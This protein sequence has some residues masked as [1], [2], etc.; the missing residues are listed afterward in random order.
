MKIFIDE[1]GSFNWHNP[2]RSIFCG[3]SIPDRDLSAVLD[4]F[5]RWRRSIIGHSKRELKGAELTDAQLS[6]FVSKVLP[7][8]DKQIW[9]TIVG[10]DT[11]LT[12]KNIILSLREQASAILQRSSEISSEH[13]NLRLKEFYRQMSGWMKF[14]SPENLL[15]IIGL[16]QAV[17]DAL[18]HTIIR[19]MEPEDDCEFEDIRIFMDQSFICRE[20]HVTFWREWLRAALAKSS[21]RDFTFIPDTW[22]PR[23][24]PFI[25]QYEIH[26]GLLNLNH[27]FVRNTGF[28]R[29]ERIEGIQI[30]DIC[31]HTFY[32][33]HLG[34]GG[35]DAYKMLRPRIVGRD[36]AEIK[37]IHL[38]QSSLHSDDPRNHAGIFDIEEYKARADSIRAK[39]RQFDEDHGSRAN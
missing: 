30:A 1:A 35:R 8:S 25:L 28:F 38:D 26:P 6:S 33:Y 16:E 12:Q 29:S 39:P 18:Q 27:L 10:V 20:E 15:W 37:I 4:R 11:R 32:R 3:V 34:T 9:L 31:A 21:R 13:S 2:G 5:A 14:R 17:I 19:F 36:G 22:R 23:H 7:W 24:H